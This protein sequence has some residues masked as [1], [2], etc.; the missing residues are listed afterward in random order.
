MR[1]ERASPTPAARHLRRLQE[2]DLNLLVPLQAL[3][4][5]C[6][7]SRAAARLAMSQ[8][9]M[10]RALQ[11]LREVFAD[12]LLVRSREGYELTPRAARLRHELA[13][14]VPQLTSLLGASE[15]DPA[16]SGETFR[17][18]G[19][20][21]A[22]AVLA[23][24]LFTVA[25]HEAPN[26]VVDFSAWYD[27]VTG[28]VERGVLDL[29]VAAA[30]ADPP[31]ASEHLFD[32]GHL[33]LVDPA[34]PAA[35]RGLDL[36]AFY[37]YPHVAVGFPHGVPSPAPV[38]PRLY[39][40]RRV[41]ARVPYFGS[42]PHVVRGTE[43]IATVPARLGTR[44]VAEHGLCGF[45]PPVTLAPLRCFMVWHPRL[46]NY[47]AHRW[48]RALVRR[49]ARALPPPNVDRNTTFDHSFE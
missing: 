42:V 45:P 11:R 39:A 30:A 38:V 23:E 41:A 22:L 27:G 37:R 34:H 44:L 25:P 49:T 31:L 43:L 46:E 14:V 36:A 26:S 18:A 15:F 40:N 1:T 17:V 19:T 10:S 13:Q 9:A 33:C 12:E 21:Y 3:L 16:T 5:E 32:D 8:P 20:D 48:L 35:G 4:E 2:V 6:H 28:A 47:P 29:L 24:G 7:V